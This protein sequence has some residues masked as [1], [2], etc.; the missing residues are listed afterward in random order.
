MAQGRVEQNLRAED[1]GL[2]ERARVENRAVHVRLGREV[3]DG[4]AALSS[5]GPRPW[6]RNV[7]FLIVSTR[8]PLRLAGLPA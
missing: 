7:S 2:K 6:D 4:I 3:D 8:R 1:V 5:R